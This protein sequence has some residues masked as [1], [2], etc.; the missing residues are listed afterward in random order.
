[1]KF[2]NTP[3]FAG[4]KA[5][6]SGNSQNFHS[7][8]TAAIQDMIVEFGGSPRIESGLARTQVCGT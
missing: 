6:A 2:A 3:F 7:F 4:E 1:M 8:V 5:R